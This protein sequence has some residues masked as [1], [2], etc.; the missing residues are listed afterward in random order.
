[1]GCFVWYHPIT[2]ISNYY[3]QYH[4]PDNSTSSVFFLP[5]HRPLCL[6]SFILFCQIYCCFVGLFTVLLLPWQLGK[7]HT[8][9]C[10]IEPQWHTHTHT[11]T[12]MKHENNHTCSAVWIIIAAL[13][14]STW[15]WVMHLHLQYASESCTEVYH[16]TH[17]FLL[18]WLCLCKWGVI[19]ELDS[20]QYIKGRTTV[21]QNLLARVRFSITTYN[22]FSETY[23]S[24]D[25]WNSH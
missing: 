8:V 21:N 15:R 11:Q 14:A 10:Y 23:G 25:W 24:K 12:N 6:V 4:S 20:F 3:V 9:E 5:C 1:M 7:K 22:N 2:V 19:S 18:F 16:R 13:D 17:W